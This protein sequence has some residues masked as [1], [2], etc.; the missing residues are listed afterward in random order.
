MEAS[1]LCWLVA[2]R[3]LF[4][5]KAENPRCVCDC[6]CS[7]QRVAESS[8]LGV[9]WLIVLIGLSIL[10]FVGAGFALA[11][12]LTVTRR[13]D[14]REVAIQFKGKSKGVYSPIRP[15]QILG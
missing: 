5:E 12:K 8:S 10:V 1:S 3:G 2:V 15:L 9:G 13:G 7:V 14:D 4:P 6:H 11:V